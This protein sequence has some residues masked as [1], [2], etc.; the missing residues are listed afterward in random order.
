MNIESSGNVCQWL[1]SRVWPYNIF[2]CA[3]NIN[4]ACPKHLVPR[5]HTAR[6]TRAP[7]VCDVGTSLHTHG[8]RNVHAP[9]HISLRFERLRLMRFTH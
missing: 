9:R 1:L 6:C 2:I 8:C 7:F 3:V 4:G 5:K